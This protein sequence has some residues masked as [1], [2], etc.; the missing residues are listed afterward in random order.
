M[1]I[2]TQGEVRVALGLTGTFSDADR[3]TMEAVLRQTDAKVRNV[4]RYD[5]ERKVHTNRLYPVS[6]ARSSNVVGGGVWDVNTAGTRAILQ[7]RAG[8]GEL[9]LT[10]LPVRQITALS[11]D[12]AAHAG[13]ASGAF[14]TALTEGT[15]FYTDWD[16]TNLGTDGAEANDGI[17]YSGLVYRVGSHWPTRARSVQV[18]YIGGFTAD[19][20]RGLSGEADGTNIHGAA[21]MIAAATFKRWKALG[22]AGGASAL[23]AGVIESERMGEYSYKLRDSDG[24]GGAGDVSSMT[25]EV[26]TAAAIALSSHVNIGALWA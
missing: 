6:D 3:A 18:T 4:L 21:V 5:P 12:R 1:T 22:L 14:G 11:E 19:E 15:D 10:H 9:Q 20:L 16:V 23:V 13:K 8:G 24:A 7:T 25:I 26:P 2:S 17:S